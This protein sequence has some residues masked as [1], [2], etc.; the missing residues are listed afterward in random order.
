[1][2]RQE[3]KLERDRLT[4]AARATLDEFAGRYSERVLREAASLSR[5]A[6]LTPEDVVNAHET[7]QAR[8]EARRSGGALTS[9]RVAEVFR[10]RRRNILLILIATYSLVLTVL[11]SILTSASL[12]EPSATLNVV[13]IGLGV[14]G[15][16]AL[17]V[18]LIRDMR[19]SRE[20]QSLSRQEQ[21]VRWNE[22][23][24][25]V[26]TGGSRSAPSRQ[27]LRKESE[28]ASNLTDNMSLVVRWIELEQD[29]KILSS[30]ALSIPPYQADLMPIGELLRSLHR[31][32][33]LDE[34]TYTDLRMVLEGRN[35]IVHGRD[36]SD[37]ERERLSSLTRNLGVELRRLIEKQPHTGLFGN[38]VATIRY[39]AKPAETELD[40]RE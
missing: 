9:M 4:P 27:Q 22:V 14:F 24:G 26:A 36:I 20:L 17:A 25:S 32:E 19:E 8:N 21:L 40:R 3:I 2:P 29:L 23:R 30:R 6:I 38:D 13:Q 1:M 28:K 5:S 18:A 31:S 11:T 34:R 33:V 39:R 15:I 7:I 37:T 16:C 35:R 10:Q 12:I